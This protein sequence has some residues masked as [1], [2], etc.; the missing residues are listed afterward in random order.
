MY[1]PDNF[2]TAPSFKR[3]FCPS[4]K[5]LI[6]QKLWVHFRAGFISQ[7]SGL[8]QINARL[9]TLPVLL[10]LFLCFVFFLQL[11]AQHGTGLLVRMQDGL[12]PDILLQ[13]WERSSQQSAITEKKVS[14][15]LNI[16]LLERT[17]ETAESADLLQWLRQQ[18]EVHTAQFNHTLTERNNTPNDPLFMQQW[19]LQNTGQNGGSVGADLG[20]LPAW[21]ITTGGLTPAG[22]TIVV[23]VIDGGLATAHPDIAPNLWYNWADIP[24]D[25]IDND[26]N[27][28][29]DDRMGWNV[30][31][32]NDHI[33]GNSTAHG[34]PVSAIIGAKGNNNT[35][36]AGI[37]WHIKIMFVAGGGTEAAILEAYDYI[38]QARQRYNSSHGQEGAFVVAVNCSW[39]TNYG[40]PEDAPLWCAAFDTLG[41]AGILSIASTANIPVDVDVAGDLPTTC[42]SDFMVA[43]TSLGYTNQKAAN[44]AWGAQ[45][46]DLGA[47]GQDVYTA[48][49]NNAYGTFSGTS[50]AAPQVSGA[51]GLL[52]A[53]PC[54]NLISLTKSDPGA[55][56]LWVKNLILESVAPNADLNGT[57]VSGG[58]LHLYQMLQQYEN[59][60]AACP[61]PF[62]LQSLAMGDD[63]ALLSWTGIADFDTVRMRWRSSGS[64]DWSVV[65]N[66]QSPFL[67]E[68]LSACA[69]YEFATSA[70]CLSA[71]TWSAWSEAV[72][73]ITDG[74]CNA[75][76]SVQ[77]NEIGATDCTI[78]WQQVLAGNSYQ[79]RLRA[80]GTLVWEHWET[81]SATAQITGLLPCTSYELQ[82]LTVCDTGSTMYSA[83]VFFQT[84]GCGSC[85]DANYCAA[86]AGQST[87]EWI[88]NVSVDNWSHY[89]GT[90]GAGYQNFTGMSDTFLQ[91]A[92]QTTVPVHITP[93]FAG[94]PFKEFF[95]IYIDYNMD[96]DFSDTGEL[97][98]DPGYAHD[99]SISGFITTPDFNAQ[100]LTR[101][102]V[103]M[104]FKNLTNTMPLSCESFDYGQ[105]EDYCI[106]LLGESTPYTLTTRQPMELKIYPQPVHHYVRVAFPED[107][108]GEWIWSVN[109][110]NGR[111][112]QSG[113][114]WLGRFHDITMNTS[115]WLPGLYVVT[116]R[117]E[118]YV[119]RGKIMKM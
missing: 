29:T 74:C 116:A 45:H 63:A 98:F 37:N 115:N 12:S 35:G 111:I 96:G 42:S 18:P 91:M 118:E 68:N 2:N 28:F 48:A 38:W 5:D 43:V 95:R 20:A 41:Q 36:V 105:V 103:M 57:T 114:H 58:G 52:Y 101:M 85:L 92:P 66:V 49:A 9:R 26:N 99:G 50:F 27:G 97:A 25:Y 8:F 67:L 113:T 109:D 119:F 30:W 71:E 13:R 17:G 62:N 110:M 86:A 108:C 44:A 87:Y 59:Q 31:T 100:G 90:A 64:T 69:S 39:G 94:L 106:E 82:I 55:A 88:E 54:P 80:A 75:P 21:D 51:V 79:L 40:L 78:S 81:T 61:A 1:A 4:E 33:Q 65:E 10:T 60:C 84:A 89:S 32:Q 102:R 70:Y 15:S 19:Q 6:M 11:N 93:G 56:A 47:Y 73:F 16:W 7:D 23:A 117:Q 22:D 34:T 104:K 3:Y 46:V 72:T 77:L 14:R 53:A 112:I 83:P 76:V 107:T 24:G